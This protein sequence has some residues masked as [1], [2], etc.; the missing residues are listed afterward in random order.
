M[1]RRPEIPQKVHYKTDLEKS[2]LITNWE[3]RGWTKVPDGEDWSVYWASVHTIKMIFNPD[4][5][6]R[7]LDHQVLNHFPNHY[8][9]TRKDLMVKNLKRYKKELEREG[10]DSGV[11]DFVPLT[12]SLPADYS[13]F[14]DVFR[15]NPHHAWIMKPSSKAQGRGI[16]IVNKLSQ[17]RKW[18]NKKITSARD[19][20]VV[21]QYINKPLLIGGKKFDLRLYVLVTSFRPMLAY[22]H[23]EGFARFCNVK[24]SSDS[25]NFD[26][27]FI[28]LTNVAIQ[29]H[30]DE[31][32]SS[33]GSKFPLRNLM[34]LIEHTH[35]KAAVVRLWE[36]IKQVVVQTLKSVQSII[37]N[38]KHCFECYGYDIIID[39]ELKPWLIEVNASPSLTA[40]TTSDRLLKTK[41]LGDVFRLVCPQ[42]WPSETWRTAKERDTGG[43]TV[44]VDEFT[45][46]E[47]DRREKRLS[48]QRALLSQWR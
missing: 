45:Q 31:Y 22:I 24:Y 25:S 33:H 20:Y 26:N 15:R 34:L 41:V 38:D 5:G 12:Y 17:I 37:I 6:R 16:F 23:D 47:S 44:L 28:H 36:D 18:E 13:L 27:P 48:K 42:K 8:E 7:L 4:T 30:N 19:S 35:G 43:F 2:T 21:S 14:V 1:L 3:K 39:K 10:M 9:L 46:V 11:L 32:S 29:K 40:T